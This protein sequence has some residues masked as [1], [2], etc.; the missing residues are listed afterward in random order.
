MPDQI[1]TLD[2]FEDEY[3]K[4]IGVTLPSRG[5]REASLDNIQRF[6]DGVGD[7]NPLWR[8]ESHAAASRYKGITAPPMFIYGASLG[9]SA[10]INGACL[11]YTSPSPRDATLSRMPSSA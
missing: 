6:G 2:E 3:H 4:G 7:Y 10:A 9:I 5:S 8:D 11:L 1:T